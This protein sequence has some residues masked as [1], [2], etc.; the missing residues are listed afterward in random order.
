MDIAVTV[1]QAPRDADPDGRSLERR[2]TAQGAPH[3]SRV[4]GFVEQE[5]HGRAGALARLGA[6]PAWTSLCS[7][8]ANSAA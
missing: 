2:Q 4:P 8:R 3:A 5:M 7:M 6:P 1:A